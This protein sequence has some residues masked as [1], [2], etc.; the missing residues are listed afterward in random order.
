MT[1]NNIVKQVCK[2]LGVTQKELAEMIGINDGTIRQWSSKGEV[3]EWAIKFFDVL[4]D[5]KKKDSIISALKQFK[6]VLHELD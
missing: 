6:S 2:E 4:I 1:E 3:P 5:N